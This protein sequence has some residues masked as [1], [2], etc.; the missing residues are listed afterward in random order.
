MLSAKDNLI[1]LHVDFHSLFIKKQYIKSR[2]YENIKAITSTSDNLQE[3][4]L[5]SILQI[6]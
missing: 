1:V 4:C 2:I 5:K 6:L 3:L